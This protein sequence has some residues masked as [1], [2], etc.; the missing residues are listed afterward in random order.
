MVS[1]HSWPIGAFGFVAPLDLLTGHADG[2]HHL[3]RA[4]SRSPQVVGVVPA[5]GL[6]KTVPF[7]QEVEGAGLPVV[8]GK[9]AGA[10]ALTGGEAIVDAR[11]GLR[12]VLPSEPIPYRGCGKTPC[13]SCPAAA[14][15]VPLRDP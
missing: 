3:P 6:R 12:H 5:Y 8:G 1:G 2:D 14:L 10:G 4:P 15:V 13:A 7:A 11:Y 9:D